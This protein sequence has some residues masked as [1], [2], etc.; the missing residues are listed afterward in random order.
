MLLFCYADPRA[1]S[2]LCQ[3]PRLHVTHRS[4]FHPLR[5]SSPPAL[6]HPQLLASQCGSGFP[7]LAHYSSS[8]QL[9]K[10]SCVR[11]YCPD[12]AGEKSMCFVQSH[13][14]DFELFWF[15]LTFQEQ[16]ACFSRILSCWITDCRSQQ[17]RLLLWTG[18]GSST[19]LLPFWFC[20]ELPSLG[21]RGSRKNM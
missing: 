13:W 6:H 16:D 15:S 2:F 9:Y 10:L 21:Y 8:L 5:W 4:L 1:G 19:F 20:F 7:R 3:N 18:H 14:L 12:R 17:N 11:S